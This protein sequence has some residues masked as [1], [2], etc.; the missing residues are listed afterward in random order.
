MPGPLDPKVRHHPQSMRKA[1]T[2]LTLAAVCAAASSAQND[3]VVLVDGTKISNVRVTGFDLNRLTYKKRGN[4][5]LES[6]DRIASLDIAKVSDK[7]RRAFSAPIAERVGTFLQLAEMNES[8]PFIAQF[9]YYEAAQLLLR[10]G[11]NGDAFQVLEELNKKCPNSG[12]L[13]LLYSEKCSYYAAR[14]KHV[15]LAKVAGQYSLNSQAAGYP[16]GAQLE[17]R[18]FETLSKGL[19]GTMTPKQ[20]AGEMEKIIRD[21]GSLLPQVS[22]RARLQIANI[23]RTAGNGKDARE[24]YQALVE[25]EKA[26]AGVRGA[27][28]LGIGHLNIE[29]GNPSNKQA[30]K[31][32]MLAFLRVYLDENT[33]AD[34]K[35][36]A[37]Y[38]GSQAAKQWGGPTSSRYSR[39]LRG[40]LLRVFPNSEWAKK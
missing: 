26:D 3:T 5:E 31:D 32:A 23:A 15:D 16:K 38:F 34:L 2:T 10:N 36:E 40:R 19:A 7:Y 8:D 12:Y 1:F 9:G 35:A 30:Y 17:A 29:S 14:G 20:L 13:P 27:A 25:D 18:Y 6:S 33:S 4:E 39:T 11:Q 24:A 22:G 37:L 28:W 21:A